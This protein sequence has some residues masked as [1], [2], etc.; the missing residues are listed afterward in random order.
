ME[1]LTTTPWLYPLLA[2][3]IGLLIGSFL[4]VVIYRYPKMM[5]YQW[6]QEFIEHFPQYDNHPTEQQY[7]DLSLP[8]SFCPNCKSEIKPWHN[9]P[10]FSYLWLRGK[11]AHCH[12]SI[13]ARYPLVEGL[14]ALMC[15]FIATQVPFSTYS[16]AL[17]IFSWL[18]ISAAF[19]DL[20]TMLLPDSLTFPML[21]LGIGTAL[22]GFSPVSLN[23]A[24]LGAMLGYLSLWSIYWLFRILTRKEGMGHGDFKLLAALGAWFGWQALPM[25]VLVSSL[26][27]VVFGLIMLRKEKETL[28]RSFPFGPSLALAGWGY[29]AWHTPFI[30]QLISG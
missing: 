10:L 6:Q 17:M 16:V 19:I 25:L 22:L 23:N 4:N 20:E 7:L 3:T 30:Q 1:L 18:L 27:G 8:H 28:N 5:E 2:T 21:W 14:S 11:C 15:G 26:I 9:I 13:S 12:T 24:V 29:F